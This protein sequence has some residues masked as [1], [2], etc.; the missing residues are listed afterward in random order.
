MQNGSPAQ[1]V[2]SI[3]PNLWF[4]SQLARAY[5]KTVDTGYA[6]LSAELPGGGWPLGALMELLVQQ[7]GVG[8]MRLPE[9]VRR[10]GGPTNRR[11]CPVVPFDEVSDH[12]TANAK[13]ATCVNALC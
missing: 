13:P 12:I 1:H 4:G 2:E 9:T 5:R 11:E 8:E 10:A 6:A 3:H 7:P